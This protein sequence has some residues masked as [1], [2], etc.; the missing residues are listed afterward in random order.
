MYGAQ[1]APPQYGTQ[2]AGWGYL[3]IT[4]D[5]FPLQWIKSF[6]TPTL[7]IDG[8]PAQKPW[9]RHVVPLAPGNHHVRV[10][11]PYLFISQSGLA[12]RVVPI[13]AGMATMARYEAPWFSFSGGTLNVLSTRPA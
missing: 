8:Y 3:D 12:A 4:L 2:Q 13:Y 5:Y 7:E 6:V 9:G 11:Y 1:G 10:H